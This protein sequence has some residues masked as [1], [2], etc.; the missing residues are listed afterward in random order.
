MKHENYFEIFLKMSFGK[1]KMV[2][3]FEE[4]IGI[5]LFYLYFYASCMLKLC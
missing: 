2:L 1:S 5:I 4:I 3:L